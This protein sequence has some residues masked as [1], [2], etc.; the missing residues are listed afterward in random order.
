MSTPRSAGEPFDDRDA[1]IIVRSSD[2][3]DFKVHKALLAK[4][5]HSFDE[6][7]VRPIFYHLVHV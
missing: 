3:V 4:L 6:M 5:F 7:L 1:D 2:L